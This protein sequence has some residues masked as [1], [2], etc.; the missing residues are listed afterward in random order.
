MTRKLLA[1]LGLATLWQLA[2]CDRS[3][4]E[5]VD[6]QPPVIMPDPSSGGS[7]SGSSLPDSVKG[8]FSDVSIFAQAFAQQTYGLAV[9]QSGT[10]TKVLADDL[11]GDRHQRFVLK[12]SNAQTVLV[13]HNI[14][15][16]PRLAGVA[17]GKTV[18]F[19]GVYE[20][21]AEGGVV[22]W[23]HLDPAGKHD[24]GWLWMDGQRVQ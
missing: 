5:T 14:D 23:T 13:A 17:A 20:W 3:S 4:A 22:H 1:F 12:L 24:A 6:S 9:S 7:A 19:K 8:G 15:L 18:A 16:A 2:A 21:N 11:E 10:V